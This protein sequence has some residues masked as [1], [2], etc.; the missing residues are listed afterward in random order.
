MLFN[1][2][3][4]IIFFVLNVIMI[5][6][7]VDKQNMM[8]KALVRLQRLE[9]QKE[10]LLQEKK[11]LMLQ[12]ESLKQLSHVERYATD[13]LQMQPITIKDIKAIA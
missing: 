13:V 2:K 6:L 3:K 11:E 4:W 7:L 10:Q 9:E 1:K 8:I 5:F 12:V